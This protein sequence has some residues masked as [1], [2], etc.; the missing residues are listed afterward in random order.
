MAQPYQAFHRLHEL[1]AS[2]EHT[3]KTVHLD[4][5]SAMTGVSRFGEQYPAWTYDYQYLYLKTEGLND[6]ATVDYVLTADP[7]H[8][9]K[10]E[11]EVVD[12]VDAFDRVDAG[13]LAIVQKPQ[14]YI[15]QRKP[16]QV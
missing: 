14:I 12:T 1:G 13:R 4:V 15:L 10:Q 8:P 9:S 2:F 11:F 6:F 5:A 7:W 16:S 3:P